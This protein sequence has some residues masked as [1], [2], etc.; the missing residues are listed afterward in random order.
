[1]K[2][3]KTSYEYYGHVRTF[4][5]YPKFNYVMIRVELVIRLPF[6]INA[7]FSVSNNKK[8]DLCSAFLLHSE[9]K[10]Y[11]GFYRELNKYILVDWF[12]VVSFLVRVNR[13]FRVKIQ[14]QSQSYRC[15][16][17]DGPG[18]TSNTLQQS[19]NV[20]IASTFQC[21]L[22]ILMNLSPKKQR[23]GFVIFKQK[24][25]RKQHY[26]IRPGSVSHL[27]TTN[28]NCGSRVCITFIKTNPRFHLNFSVL[29]IVSDYKY[30]SYCL[31]G[32]IIIAE[33]NK[34]I[35]SEIMCGDSNYLNELSRSFYSVGNSLLYLLYG[36]TRYT[37]I[38]SL[39]RISTTKCTTIRIDAF[40]FHSSCTKIATNFDLQIQKHIAGSLEPT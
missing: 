5:L 32:G 40:K 11:Y 35:G 29:N 8:A 13:L 14:V 19:R 2:T 22:Q 28:K 4:N 6:D 31:Y 34:N 24:F 36:Y 33:D 10:E 7:L 12:S 21:I 16:A 30:H 3:E 25:K 15:V 9:I 37:E 39:V 20:F 17:Y 26:I 38:S 23:Y 27:V 18:F 1:M